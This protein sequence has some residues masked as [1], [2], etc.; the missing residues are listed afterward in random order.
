MIDAL[1]VADV[2]HRRLERFA[3]DDDG[4]LAKGRRQPHRGPKRL[5]R[6]GSP[7]PRQRLVARFGVDGHIRF[8]GWASS[9]RS[10]RAKRAD[11]VPRH[12]G[13]AAVGVEQPHRRAV[14]RRLE[15]D[16]AIGA[17]ARVALAQLARQPIER[18]AVNTGLLDVKEVVPVGVRLR[19]SDHT[20]APISGRT[21]AD[22]S[23]NG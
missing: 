4:E 21:R 23:R 15:D 11:A 18:H 7:D 10:R 8:G 6:A 9:R 14:R 17:D 13:A 2:H 16:Q 12:L 20:Y 19:K 5:A 22:A 1:R 3:G